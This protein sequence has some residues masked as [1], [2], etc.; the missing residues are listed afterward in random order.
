MNDVE[1]LI[2]IFYL[3]VKWRWSVRLG[4][5]EKLNY[6]K[7]LVIFNDDRDILNIFLCYIELIYSYF[8]SEEWDIR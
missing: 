4:G 8:D 3:V 5:R 6:M 1:D 7:E 2:L